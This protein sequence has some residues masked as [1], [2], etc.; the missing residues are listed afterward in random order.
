MLRILGLF[1]LFVLP[2]VACKWDRDTLKEESKGNLDTVKA[3]TGW[4]DRYPARYYEMRLE[5]VAKEVA[6][7]PERLDLYDDA[8]VAC[9]RLGRFDDAIAWMERKDARLQAL[10]AADNAEHRYR[11]LANLGSFY[12][13]RWISRAPEVRNA[14]LAD[15]REA[16][17]LVAAAIELNP[18][19][20]FGRER[21]QLQMIRWLLKD[22]PAEKFEWMSFIE[23]EAWSSRKSEEK[24]VAGLTG[25]ILLGEGWMSTDIFSSLYVSLENM[26]LASLAELAY[27]R[28]KELEEAGAKSLHPLEEV[29]A[30][31]GYEPSM[32]LTEEKRRVVAEYFKRARAAAKSRH[33]AWIQYQE[34][35]FA[36]GQHPDSDPRFWDEWKEPE[37]PEFPRMTFWEWVQRN[38]LT[39]FWSA[40]VLTIVGVLGLLR[41]LKRFDSSKSKA[42]VA[43]ELAA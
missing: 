38:P 29:R 33:S 13:D 4:F 11:Y 32:S 7:Q 42:R 5:R 30:K 2:A 24:A 35:R 21:Y 14:D 27:C 16:E 1:V 39:A 23:P 41:F 34:A 36:R 26:N 43:S 17:K 40:F 25:L 9:D 37:F 15:L 12:M 22:G 31:M 28:G 10:P 8:G 18:D 3:I 20:H 6:D 19:A